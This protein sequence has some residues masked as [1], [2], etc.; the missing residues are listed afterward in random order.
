[1]FCS[2]LGGSNSTIFFH[3]SAMLST[4]QVDGANRAVWPGNAFKEFCVTLLPSLKLDPNSD[5]KALET[6]IRLSEN[7]LVGETSSWTF[8]QYL[9]KCGAVESPEGS[10]DAITLNIGNVSAAAIA[11]CDPNV[12]LTL[13][14]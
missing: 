4:S 13:M 11:E 7:F 10:V 9:G 6:R 3:H 1:M 12:R 14:Q 2:L 5:G 8:S